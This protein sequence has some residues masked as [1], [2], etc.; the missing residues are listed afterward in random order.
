[1]SYTCGQSSYYPLCY[2]EILVWAFNM[3]LLRNY[4]M[5]SN[6]INV[7]C[8]LSYVTTNLQPLIKQLEGLGQANITIMNLNGYD[9]V[10]PSNV[11]GC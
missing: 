10:K 5:G 6:W 3:D 9:R 8:R 11:R 2:F 1:M 7:R 4:T